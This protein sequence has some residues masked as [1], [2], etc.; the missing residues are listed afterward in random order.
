[1]TIP[2]YLFANYKVDKVVNNVELFLKQK[3]LYE[4]QIYDFLNLKSKMLIKKKNPMDL[5][6]DYIKN[7]L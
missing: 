5:A 1:N 3:E 6:V 7:R 2:E 4:S